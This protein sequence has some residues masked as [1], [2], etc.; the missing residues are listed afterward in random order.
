MRASQI[1]VA[2]VETVVVVV[3]AAFV[4]VAVIVGVTVCL[5]VVVVTGTLQARPKRPSPE[6]VDPWGHAVMHTPAERNLLF[7]HFTHS[8]ETPALNMHAWQSVVHLH[9]MPVTVETRAWQ[10]SPE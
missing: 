7:L 1:S 10:S 4:V 5:M 8:P 3:P 6:D 9:A 2:A